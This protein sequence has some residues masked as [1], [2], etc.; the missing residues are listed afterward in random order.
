MQ[1][2][3]IDKEFQG[4]IPPLTGEEF[5]GLEYEILA[6]GCR[7]ALVVWGDILVD[8]HNRHRIC[9]ENKV[10]FRTVNRDFTDR[11]EASLWILRHARNRRN[12][13]TAQRIASEMKTEEIL[14][15]QAKERQG[16]RV[17]LK[18]HIIPTSGEVKKD[19]RTDVEIAKRAGVG[20]DTVHKYRVVQKEGTPSVKKKMENSEMTIN[21]A[22]RKTRGIKDTGRLKPAT[23]QRS[24]CRA[25]PSTAMSLPHN[26]E[27]AASLL[28][29]LFDAKFIEQ[30]VL[31]LQTLIAET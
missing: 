10:E 24:A 27:K 17:D 8:G 5:K 23:P 13:S 14:K 16:A 19:G 1:T 7:D 28:V 31:K 15:R 22:Y 25:E 29:R 6:D 4:L 12:M 3:T 20:K 18:E 26:V 21:A 30:L 2:L 11:D 9:T